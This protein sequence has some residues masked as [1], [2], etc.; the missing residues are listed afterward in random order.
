MNSNQSGCNNC[1]IRTKLW[2]GTLWKYS[3]LFLSFILHVYN[4]LYYIY[5]NI[6]LLG[7][8]INYFN[9]CNQYIIHDRQEQRTKHCSQEENRV[10]EQRGENHIRSDVQMIAATQIV[11]LSRCTTSLSPLFSGSSS[12]PSNSVQV[13]LN[14]TPA[15]KNKKTQL[16]SYIQHY[17]I[18]QSQLSPIQYLHDLIPRVA[19]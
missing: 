4:N 12:A 8:L 18:H 15:H 17:L 11:S 2:I 1:P 14:Y 9:L 13:Q 3:F 5:I 10:I 19:S 6:F 7:R 16:Y